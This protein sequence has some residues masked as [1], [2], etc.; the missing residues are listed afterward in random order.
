MN[1]NK[2]PEWVLRHKEKG[3][4][5]RVIRGKY[6]LYEVSCYYDK[7]TKKP[8][9]KTGKM[10]GRI[11]EKDGF[12]K[13]KRSETNPTIE[14][15]SPI[16]KI[17]C[18]E[19]G[20]S[21]YLMNASEQIISA[22]KEVFPNNWQ[23]L[24]GLVY[25]RLG[26]QVPLKNVPFLLEESALKKHLPID[27]INEKSIRETLAFCG[28]NKEQPKDY[29]RKFVKQGAYNLIDATEFF[30][31]S[32]KIPLAEKGYNKDMVFDDQISLLYIYSANDMV[33]VYYRLLAGN[34]REVKT[35]ALTVKESMIENAILI[36]D[37]GFYSKANIIELKDKN[38]NFLIPVKR[39][40]KNI[41]YQLLENIESC[42]NYFKY[43]DRYIYYTSF[44]IEDDYCI[45]F[46]DGKLKEEEK[47]DYLNRIKTHPEKF[48]H[49]KF[50]HKLSSFGTIA[51]LTDM[52]EASPE[53]LYL[54]Y[55]SRAHIEQMFDSLK[56]VLAAD[57]SYMQDEAMLE[58]WMFV[59]HIALQ[60]YHILYK[61][62]KDKELLKTYSV[63]DILLY[64]KNIKQVS[65]A[66]EWHTTEIVSKTTKALTK[67][68][69]HITCK[70]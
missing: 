64:L 1:K 14:S 43:K 3:T 40:N 28:K 49:E 58:G 29:M 50:L 54:T 34:L 55:K 51:L 6:Y 9:K 37:K 24:L 45:L 48:S 33:P 62:L 68:G 36:A 27:S 2:H 20:L 26:W 61:K 5:L 63:E 53:S 56:N 52:K 69:L 67:L 32:R 42:E 19:A 7:E 17:F 8:K 18:R 11:T 59:N 47:T 44:E 39:N 31:K 60:Y 21:C 12:I 66:G 13:S 41:D 22:L 57:V 46:W 15:I 38:L 65:I 10:L 30:S 70:F 16:G 25:C 35:M 23:V 4:E